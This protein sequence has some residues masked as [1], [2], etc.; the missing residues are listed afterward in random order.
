MTELVAAVLESFLV[1]LQCVLI[2]AERTLL[3]EGFLVVIELAAAVLESFLVHL[4][5]VLIIAKRTLLRELL[6]LLPSLTQLARLRLGVAVRV[7]ACE[8]PQSFDPLL[9]CPTVHLHCSALIL[10]RA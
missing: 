4:H 6:E 5:C 8:H 2:I 3:L 9:E 10:V 1:H 7:R